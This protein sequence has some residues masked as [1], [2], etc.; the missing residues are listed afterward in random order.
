LTGQRTVS[1]SSRTLLPV[2][3]WLSANLVFYCCAT[4]RC[5]FV[6]LSDTAVTTEQHNRYAKGVSVPVA[7]PAVRR[8]LLLSATDSFDFTCNC[9][10]YNYNDGE[11]RNHVRMTISVCLLLWQINRSNHIQITDWFTYI[12]LT[13]LL[14]PRSTVLL[15]KLTGL[16]LVKKFPSFYGTRRSITTFASAS[17]L[18]LFWAS[19]IQSILPHPN[20]W[21]SFLI[22]SSYLSL[23]LP[24]CPFPSDLPTKIVYTPFL[25]PIR[26]TC[27]AYPILLDKSHSNKMTD[28]YKTW[29]E[30]LDATDC[31]NFRRFYK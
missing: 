25:S 22:L 4:G 3:S 13:Y 1:F 5:S 10:F 29:Y 24:S 12:I 16:K 11:W 15:E 9:Q 19:S 6:N 7:Y 17:H 20:S 31:L 21:R 27:P 18:S 28:F 2:L 23:G 8:C 14:A 30:Y 26:A